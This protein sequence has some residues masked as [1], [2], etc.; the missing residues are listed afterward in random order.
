MDR[1]VRVGLVS[2]GVVHLAA[3][4]AR[5]CS[6]RSAAAAATP[7][8]RAPCSEL[9]KTRLGRFF[10]YVAAAGFVA[11]VVWQVLEAVWGHRDEDGGKRVLK[12]V[13]SGAKVVLYGS[14]A[15]TASRPRSGLVERGGGTEGLTAKLMNAARR[16]AARR[17]GRGRR[18]G[19]SPASWPTGAGRRSSAPSW[20]SRARPAR[21]ARP[22]SS[23]GKVGYI[24]KGVALAV[25]GVLFLYAAFTH[26]PQKSGGLD[27]R[28]TRCS[29]S[30]SA[31]RCWWS[32]RSASRATACSASPGPATSTA[33]PTRGI[34]SGAC[35]GSWTSSDARRAWC[36]SSPSSPACCSTRSWRPTR[37]GRRSRCS[38]C[39]S[40]PSPC[41]PC[42]PRRS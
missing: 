7:R 3:R 12:R 6:S 39:W 33:E 20:S 11:L 38:G 42:A 4:V 2:Y 28:C 41:S 25:I 13:T 35:R 14:L 30:R 22:T 31:P 10:L 40:S 27:R 9:A 16:P 34:A 21:T 8:T 29:S 15:I 32:S 36:C 5:R 18:A 17:P 23:F 1:A 24:A 19:A 26:D 37:A